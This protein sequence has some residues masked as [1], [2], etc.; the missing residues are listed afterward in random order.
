MQGSSG[1]HQQLLPDPQLLPLDLAETLLHQ[2]LGHGVLRCHPCGCDEV[3]HHHDR[4]H[5]VPHPELDVGTHGDNRSILGGQ[6]GQRGVRIPPPLHP[7]AQHLC[8]KPG[9]KGICFFPSWQPALDLFIKR[10]IIN[11][12]NANDE[13]WACLN[14]EASFQHRAVTERHLERIGIDGFVMSP[15]RNIH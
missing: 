2:G 12:T 4:Q 6:L 5:G 3:L 14:G 15:A 7:M 1:T 13:V 9:S 8:I 11:K 10:V